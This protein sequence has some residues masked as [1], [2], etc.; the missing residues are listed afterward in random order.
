MQKR[1]IGLLVFGLVGLLAV[2]WGPS[3]YRQG[4]VK[5]QMRLEATLNDP[6]SSAEQSEG[7]WWTLRSRETARQ[8]AAI[9]EQ[10]VTPEELRPPAAL[11]AAALPEA[12]RERCLDR[13]QRVLRAQ[14]QV[15]SDLSI[16]TRR[17]GQ[18][19]P[20]DEIDADADAV[21]LGARLEQLAADKQWL[22]Q[23]C[24]PDSVRPPAPI[25]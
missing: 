7:A 5:R 10:A 14:Q 11:D 24:R 20:I 6:A 16:D 13:R 12:W 3:W 2:T 23:Y 21:V 1:L 19:Q 4:L 17:I 22:K 8:A 9:E 15:R 25:A 18:Q